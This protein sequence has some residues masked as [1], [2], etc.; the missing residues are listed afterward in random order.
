MSEKLENQKELIHKWDWDVL[1][2]LDS[3]RFDYFKKYHRSY[4][5]GVLKKVQSPA[6]DTFSWLQAT[7]QEYYDCTVYSSHPVLNS[8]GIPRGGYKAAPHFKRIID[9]WK[10]GW[11]NQ[12]GTVLPQSVNHS[13]IEDMAKG[14]WKGKNIIWYM[15]P[16]APWIGDTKITGISDS[17]NDKRSI[18][19]IWDLIKRGKISEDRLKQAYKDNMFAALVQVA[20]L[21]SYLKG[22]IVITADHGESLGDGGRFGH[23]AFKSDRE[24]IEVP[25]LEIEN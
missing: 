15:Q 12:Y 3:C 7:F 22:K 23:S 17:P 24:L 9:I 6:S 11:N 5:K 20:I 19:K 8:S 21:T 13:V 14:L 10:D 4:I 1:I 25:W 18:H 2:V 16:H